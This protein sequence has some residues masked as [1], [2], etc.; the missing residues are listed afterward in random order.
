MVSTNS[1]LFLTIVQLAM[2]NIAPTITVLAAD[3]PLYIREHKDVQYSMTTLFLSKLAV[4]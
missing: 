3:L 1:V 4:D 2:Q